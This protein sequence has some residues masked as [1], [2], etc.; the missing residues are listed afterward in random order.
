[1]YIVTLSHYALPCTSAFI[2][3]LSKFKSIQQNNN[4][5]EYQNKQTLSF[6]LP[7]RSTT[8]TTFIENKIRT[9]L[10]LFGIQFVE[11]NS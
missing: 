11:G 9:V 1:M 6:S 5:K 4:N 3:K 8:Q 7:L 2:G 10:A